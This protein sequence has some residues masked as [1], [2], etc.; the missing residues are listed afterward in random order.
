MKTLAA[1][2]FA[3]L[4]LG[5]TGCTSNRTHDMAATCQSLVD[6]D[7]TSSDRRFIREADKQLAALNE[8][9]NKLTRALRDIQDKDAMIY[10]SQLEQCLLM[11]KSRQS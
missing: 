1:L 3:A 10:K 11:L 7:E 4:V 9:S 2:A 6:H 5:Q 8:P